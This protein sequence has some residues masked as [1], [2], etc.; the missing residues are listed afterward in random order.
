[1]S[2]TIKTEQP[3]KP[4]PLF[5]QG[6]VVKILRRALNTIPLGTYIDKKKNVV[7]PWQRSSSS[8]DFSFALAREVGARSR[9]K[10]AR[11][12]P[13]RKKSR[14]TKRLLKKMKKMKSYTRPPVSR[15][16]GFHSYG[17][18]Q[19]GTLNWKARE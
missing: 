13:P 6:T 7:R 2:Q 15:Q 4:E 1:M 8:Q 19:R 18:R 12:P 16:V 14:T 11:R 17:N 10:M 3:I 5:I 9:A